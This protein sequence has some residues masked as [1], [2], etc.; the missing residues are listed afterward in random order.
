MITV[1]LKAIHV[2]AIAVWAGGLIWL[3]GMLVRGRGRSRAELVHIHRFGRFGFDVLVTPA[4][5]IAVAS[6]TALIFS[7]GV[8]EGWLYVKL[9]AIAGM[10]VLHLMIGS[11][12]DWEVRRAR[13]PGRAM[14]LAMA[15]ASAALAALVLWLVLAKPPIDDSLFPW[16]LLQ[17]RGSA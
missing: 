11:Y 10:V 12:L 6:G 17:R 13:A 1:W 4:A 15:A 8:A 14:R 16:W 5:V 3:P 9:A 2:I 7:A